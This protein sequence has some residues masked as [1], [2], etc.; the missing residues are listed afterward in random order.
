VSFYV[1]V[2]PAIIWCG[3]REGERKLKFCSSFSL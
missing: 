2:L 1:A 3:R